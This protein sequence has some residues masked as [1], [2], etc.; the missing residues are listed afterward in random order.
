MKV[1]RRK[2][3][4]WTCLF[5]LGT[6]IYSLHAGYLLQ[7]VSAP[8]TSLTLPPQDTI[9][10]RYPVAKTV[11]EN[12]EDFLRQSQLPADLRDP[13][14]L[15]RNIEYDL[16]TGTYI[17]RT[18]IGDME[19]G[20]PISLT[21]EEYQDYSLQESLRSY[22]R[23]K[24]EE[25]FQRSAEDGFNLLDMQFGIGAAERI[26]GP[27]GVRVRTQGSAEITMGLKRNTTKDPALPERM[28]S[29]TFFN[30][31]ENVQLNV[32][33]TVGSKV[34]FDMNYNTQT[35]FDF[36]SKKLKLAYRGDEDEIIKSIEAGNVSMTTRNSLIRGGAALFGI[37]ADLQF[38]KLRVNTLFAQQE[39][40][41]QTVNSKGGVQTKSFEITADQYDENRHFF[42]SHYFRD[43]YDNA[44]GSLPYI[45]SSITINRVEVWITNKRSSFDQARNIVAFT[46]LGE[47][48]RSHISNSGMATPTNKTIP[49]NGAN[50]LYNTLATNYSAIRDI[51]QVTQ[52]IGGVLEGGR[53]YEKIESARRLDDSEY[54]LNSQL[55]YISLRTQL[56]PDEVLAVAFEYKYGSSGEVFQVG[57]FSTD[58]VSDKTTNSLF[59]K[60]LKGK[61]L[62]PG[63]PFWDLMMKNVYSLGAY[64]VQKDKFRLNILYQSDTT[65]VYLNYLPNVTIDEKENQLLLRVMNL[66][67]LNTNNEPYP[68]GVYD[69]VEGFTI[70][71]ENGKVIFPV[72][73]PFGSHLADKI[74]NK[75]IADKFV[76]QEL[77]DSTLTIARQIAEKNKFILRGEYKASSGSEIQLGAMNVAR[78]SVVVTAGGVTL[79]ENV[80][81]TVDYTSG[82]VTILNESVIAGGQSVQVSLENQSMYSMQRKTMMGLDLNYDFSKDFSLGATIMHMSEMPLTVKTTM[83]DESIKNTLWGLNVAYKTESQWLTNMLDKIP[84]LTLTRPSQVAFNAEFAHLIAGHYENKNTGG[85]SYLDDFESSQSGFNLQLPYSWT[86]AST[87]SHDERPLFEE[88]TRTNDITYGMNRALLAWYYIDGIFTR[89]N[90]NQKPGHI[91]KEDLSK[92]AVRAVQ[93][94]ELYP[95]RDQGMNE[96]SMLPILNV[97]YYPNERG[98]YNLDAEGVN[99]D[100]TLQNPEKRWGGMMRKIDQSDF[101]T[102]NI[103]F[104]EFWMMDPF[105]VN[106]DLQGGDLYFNLGE[107][108]EDI[109][110]DEKKFFENGLPIDGELSKIDSTVWGYVP[111]EASTVYAFDN[112]TGAREIQDVGL[113][114]LS[115]DQEKR[116]STYKE[117]VDNLISKISG[118]VQA[119][120][121]NN[122]FSPIND[123]A[124]DNYMYFR[125][126]YYDAIEADILTRYKHYNGTEG[127]SRES[128]GRYNSAAKT[129][130]DVEDLN[131]D[132]TLNETE[133]YFEYKVSLRKQDMEI[134]KNHIVDI[135][136]AKPR[137]MDD[138]SDSVHWYLFKIPIKKYDRAVGKIRDFKTISFI[139]MYMTDFKEPAV[140]R[141]GSFELVRGEWRTYEQALYN[142]SVPPKSTPTFNVS[143]VNI[144]ENGDRRPVNYILP[145]GI[146]RML[147]PSQPQ[148]RQENEQ[149]LSLKVIDLSP[150][151]ARAVYKNTSYDLRQYKQL[152]L[153][154]HA[155]APIGE[156]SSVADGDFSVF[157]RLG[158]DYKNNYYEY[159]V[160]LI[161]TPHLKT[162][163]VQYDS[164]RIEDQRTVWPDSNLLDFKLEVLTNLKLS[165]NKAKRNGEV[166]VDYQKVYSEYDPGN[167]R[168]KISI[169]GNPTLSEVKTIMIGIRNNS[170]EIKTVEVWVNELRLTDFNE[171]GGW[172]ANANL[173]I[174]LSDLGTVNFSGRMETSGFGGL[175][176]SLTERRMEDYKQ[177]NVA[178]SI[179][180]GKFFPEKA[181]V[182]IPLHYSYSK[183]IVDPKYNPLDQ[184]I[185][186]SDALDA[187]ETKAEKDSIKK[188]AQ[189]HTVSKS[190]ALSNVRVNIKSKNPMPYDPANFSFGYAYR[191]D[192]RRNP[193][194]EYETTKNYQANFGYSYTPYVKPF[195]PFANIKTNNG[196]TRY[197]RQFNLNYVPTNISFQT[198][199]DRNYSEQQ[200]RDLTNVTGENNIPATFTQNWTW[201][202]AFKLNWNLTNNLSMS[203]T[204][205]TNARIE[206]P[207]T[208][209]NKKLNADGYQLWKDSVK[210]SIRDLGTPMK[211]DQTF[212]ATLNLP[213]QYIPILDWVNSSV[214]YNAMYNWDR[215]SYTGTEEYEIGNTITNQRLID[216]QGVFNMQGLY[217]KNKFLKNVNQKYSSTSRQATNRRQQTKNIKIEKDIQLNPD[218]GTVIRHD[219]LTKK[220][221]VTARTE[222]GKSYPVKFKAINYNEI[223]VLN[224][225]SVKLKLTLVPGPPAL[226]GT[227]LSVA[228]YSSRFLMMLRR[229]SVQYSVSDG[230][231]LPNFRPEIG[232][233]F[234]QRNGGNMAP[235]LGFAFG[236][237]DR[238]YIDRAKE[239]QWLVISENNITPA[240][241]NHATNLNIRANLEPIAGLKI[242]LDANR[243]ETQNTEV[244]FMYEDMPER[245]GGNFTMT[246]VA[247][248]TAFSSSGN[249]N[250]GYKSK[251]FEKFVEY[252]NTIAKRVESQYTGKALPDGG[253][254]F[255]PTKGDAVSANSADVLIPAFLAAY[256]GKSADGISLS[257]F[258]SITSLLPN[259]RITYDGLMKLE[260]IKKY[261]KSFMLSHQYRCTYNVGSYSAYSN[262]TGIDG[263]DDL[264]FI[265]DVLNGNP[266]ASSPYNITSVNL[267]ESFTPLF[268]V[269]ATLLNNM[270]ARVEY[271][272]SRNLSL[273]VT[274]YQIV[275]ALSNEVILGV[276]YKVAEFNKMLGM[277]PTQNFSNDLTIR[278]DLSY[279]KMQSLIRKIEDQLTNATSGNIA[280]TLQFSAD[281][282][283]SRALTL[284]AFYDLQINEP[285]ISATTF[286]TT[287]SSYGVS[288]RFSLAQ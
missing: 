4:V 203:F 258:P 244:D 85:Y 81:Y 173:N 126:D 219:M 58:N 170:K 281:Y 239:R 49:S 236:A 151:D 185:K 135:R 164:D 227:L 221:R 179:E 45:K 120:M 209:V 278:F 240:M 220:L 65:G 72:V 229:I 99:P 21:P 37:K 288:I 232:D 105:L 114:G 129:V 152:Q 187:V 89:R 266:V 246:T 103:E 147:D 25:E 51:N 104:I 230:M 189:D 74:G 94:Q 261:F 138:T 14:N 175:D 271:R 234:G 193:E 174:A 117:Y 125:S 3:I 5:L 56:Q 50:T 154:T 128:T 6:G 169:I 167:T 242:D 34:N 252:R 90:S 64:S 2:Y 283:V 132:N 141:F 142:P 10:S 112:S 59:V 181:Q 102:A 23:Q 13:E 155:E 110:K 251:P 249:A 253:G 255:D 12:Y 208:Q 254:F 284:R 53:E 15:K 82:I 57:E 160:P 182:S 134:G 47:E 286:P 250:N 101:E 272:K 217:N 268:G 19:F 133:K 140:L 30:F 69:F 107:I 276:G 127:N 198:A 136:G 178:T 279:R 76:F 11:P 18:K 17:I 275:E 20:T 183:E 42:L 111:K 86:L 33:A 55:G 215:G 137:L 27:G 106:P 24:N 44:L 223:R 195:A 113:N 9:P 248:R 41:S 243:V 31:D 213:L 139:R 235:G 60:L 196:Y 153:F 62:S 274:S 172:A 282:G 210:Q 96:S 177:Y 191:M 73:E 222:E 207:Y 84:L 83:G 168:N 97:A 130:P 270:T 100:G 108:S 159:E 158:S 121:Q 285:L 192:T 28:R 188:H 199:M 206:E 145:P 165:R 48:N 131:Q 186:L 92:H 26:F 66:D 52:T 171:E 122:P 77:Y 214:A 200:L 265:R 32:Q 287:N 118:E 7:I 95:Y 257:P 16:N 39:S 204:S 218:S 180:L 80:D 273:N 93:V 202:R 88:A 68:D 40:Q 259:W 237:V 115:S 91:T 1:R 71:T 38:G 262:W 226:E 233:V 228:E 148:L 22:F 36:D 119:Q 116:F 78:G 269:D 163:S 280:K 256:T 260:P 205:G 61:S 124:G 225:D 75:S 166:G 67:R 63:M 156:E 264:G 87:P 263:E 29:R 161:M 277:K 212:L 70:L 245:R 157:L 109:L 238:D 146:S 54:T 224:Q 46:D 247:I 98:P 150:Q 123:P 79:T 231:M 194:T 197:I 162:A 144:E 43:N 190:I 267:N 184:D 201:D 211:Y 8:E 35:T 143:T 149:A 241:I 176:Q 216:V